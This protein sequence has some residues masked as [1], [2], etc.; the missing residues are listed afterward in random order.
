MH[1]NFATGV[2]K[3]DQRSFERKRMEEILIPTSGK[4]VLIDKLLPKL[5]KEGHKVSV[6]CGYIYVCMIIFK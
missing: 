6:L 3:F 2:K 1:S 4:M 5:Q